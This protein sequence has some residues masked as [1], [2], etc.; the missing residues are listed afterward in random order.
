MSVNAIGNY[1]YSPAIQY[2]YFG[3]VVSNEQIRILLKKYG[4]D[5]TGDSL[6]DLRALY[7]VMYSVAKKNVTSQQAPSSATGSQAVNAGN[8]IN[9]PW[10]SL[11]SQVGLSATGNL[12]ADYEAFSNKISA[13]QA[14]GALSQQNQAS[15]DM[16]ISQAAVVFVSRSD[17]S[18]Q[19][20]KSSQNVSNV[21]IEVQLNKMYSLVTEV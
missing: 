8:S 3:T 12:T 16:L 15:V 17:S 11:M 4:I 14:S 10:A 9:V 7:E 21:D 13:L 20:Q 1:Y 5:P 18:S 6:I 2:H 19:S